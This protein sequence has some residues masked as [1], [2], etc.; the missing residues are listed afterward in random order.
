MARMQPVPTP[1]SSDNPRVFIARDHGVRPPSNIEHLI[2]TTLL[3]EARLVGKVEAGAFRYVQALQLYIELL[4]WLK[5]HTVPLVALRNAKTKL[6]ARISMVGGGTVQR[7]LQASY[8][9]L[10][11]DFDD[12]LVGG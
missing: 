2:R 11:G 3:D 12:P 1:H 6:A 7:D 5:S 8:D 9:N 10:P 4:A